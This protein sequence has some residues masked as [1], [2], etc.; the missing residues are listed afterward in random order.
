[1]TA[2]DASIPTEL[3]ARL[4]HALDAAAPRE[5]CGF[6]LGE[7][8]AERLVVRRVLEITNSVRTVGGF[9]IPDSEIRRVRRLAASWSIMILGVY[10]SHPDG[11]EG[12]SGIDRAAMAHS[13]WPWVIVTASPKADDVLL[14][15]HDIDPRYR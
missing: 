10:H 6:L 2:Q 13:E 14:A 8:E 15:W 11:Q 7:R 12:L 3:R 1:V 9:E 4:R 5:C